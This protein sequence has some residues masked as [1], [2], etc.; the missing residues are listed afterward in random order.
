MMVSR[1]PPGPSSAAIVNPPSPPSP[2]SAAEAEVRDP[3]LE[4]LLAMVGPTVAGRESVLKNALEDTM[5]TFA[6][7]G[8]PSSVE[9]ALEKVGAYEGLPPAMRARALAALGVS[10]A[11]EGKHASARRA[12]EA[13]VMLDETPEQLRFLRASS[14]ML[15]LEHGDLDHGAALAQQ[16]LAEDPTHLQALVALG[17]ASLE[18][19]DV[20]LAVDIGRQLVPLLPAEGRALIIIGLAQE[21]SLDSDPG[22]VEAVT[23][24]PPGDPWLLARIG[25]V[26]LTQ[27]RP[28]AVLRILDRIKNPSPAA[29]RTRGVANFL[30][31][32]YE[33][34]AA[35]LETGTTA[36]QDPSFVA[37]RAEANRMAGDLA[38]A[39]RLFAEV[40]PEQSPPPMWSAWADALTSLGDRAGAVRVL[41]RGIEL[42]SDETE[43]ILNRVEQ[44]LDEEGGLE[45]AERLVRR[46]LE[47]EPGNAQAHASY[48]EIL[49]RRG[50][51][52]EAMLA[53]DRALGISPDYSYAKASK[54]QALVEFGK[55]SDGLALLSEAAVTGDAEEWIFDILAEIAE[56][57][58]PDTADSILRRVQ[59]KL[60]D[61]GGDARFVYVR[62]AQLAER[63]R[64]WADADRLYTRARAA[65]PENVALILGNTRALQR[66]GRLE[67][68]LTLLDALPAKLAG[69]QELVLDRVDLLWQLGQL[70]KARSALESL[71]EQRDPPPTALAALGE[72]SL[73]EGRRTEAI[74]LANRALRGD[75]EHVYALATLGAALLQSGDPGRARERLT[76]AIDLD[77]EAEYVLNQLVYLEC[78]HGSV[79]AVEAL[80][81][82]LA[83]NAFPGTDVLYARAYALFRLGR[84]DAALAVLD[85]WL[86]EFGPEPRAFD[87]LGWVHLALGQSQRA[88]HDFVSFAE[89]APRPAYK[90]RALFGVLSADGWDDALSLVFR[91]RTAARYAMTML[92]WSHVGAW[93]EAARFASHC[94]EHLPPE[95]SWAHLVPRVLRLAGRT[96]E[97]LRIAQE[98]NELWPSN[99]DVLAELAECLQDAGQDAD[100]AEFE[101]RVVDRIETRVFLNGADLHMKARCLLRLNRLAESSQVLLG[102]LSADTWISSILFN[103]V[104]VSLLQ[105]DSRQADVLHRRAVEDLTG[106]TSATRRGIIRVAL[107]EL[108]KID[109]LLSTD[110]R[111]QANC[112]SLDLQQELTK[113]DKVLADVHRQVPQ[114]PP[115]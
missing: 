44:L 98:Q 54:A 18:R 32:K 19:G 52:E 56:E 36:E 55:V 80:L 71:A 12:H 108:A 69:E 22:L 82:R 43:L 67:A 3:V 97:A 42:H 111:A 85:E 88:V 34:A 99:A 105:E 48:G 47:L 38:T 86:A 23:A 35:D 29:A 17:R 75:P 68:A 49:R 25:E 84:Y 2:P 50:H 104:L 8:L 28:Q 60:R 30:V 93:D 40:P 14:A 61:R 58:R 24:A 13:A 45:R 64:R 94:H 1:R 63:Q 57:H 6:T 115:L 16:V 79:E 95:E 107:D 101:Q 92:L 37:L 110:S 74:E 5:L 31:G 109:P 53:F 83:T 112:F 21:G 103:L 41:E 7:G 90:Y 96:A 73:V 11:R 106:F 87:L 26:L 4:R 46:A 76:Q 62:R 114:L 70:D 39:V 15:A 9:S 89:N 65:D 51:F 20:D 102:A 113:L 100:A 10:L 59:H 66:L 72:L 27:D 91:E 81:E 77:P 78:E 33:R